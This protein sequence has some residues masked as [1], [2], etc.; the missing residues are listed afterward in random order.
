MSHDRGKAYRWEIPG[1]DGGLVEGST[2]YSSYF[3]IRSGQT[4]LKSW[5]VGS[6]AYCKSMTGVFNYSGGTFQTPT[7]HCWNQHPAGSV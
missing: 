5:G 6:S 2:T 3:S 7:T 4:V 1:F